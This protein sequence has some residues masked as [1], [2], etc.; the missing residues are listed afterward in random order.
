MPYN[1]IV[2]VRLFVPF[3]NLIIKYGMDFVNVN[4]LF[5]TNIVYNYSNS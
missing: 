2:G 1:M 5:N 3:S 4:M